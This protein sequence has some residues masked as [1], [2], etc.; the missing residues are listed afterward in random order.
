MTEG[1][2]PPRAQRLVRE[3]AER[4]RDEL[5]QMWATQDYR[6]LPGLE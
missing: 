3:W 6:Q 2:L 5:R 4:H 1:D